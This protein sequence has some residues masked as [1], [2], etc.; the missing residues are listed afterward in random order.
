M[1]QERI[2]EIK[3]KIDI[4]FVFILVL[5]SALILSF[6]FRPSKGIS[7]YEDEINQLKLDNKELSVSNDS[8]ALVNGELAIEIKNI[9]NDIDSTEAKLADNEGKIND[10]EDDKDKVSGY[11]RN[12]NADGVAES[13]NKYLDRKSQGGN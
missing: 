12:L 11:I 1:E 8:L 2:N 13:L 10:L 3:G 5:A 6:V 7:T 9:L 4:K